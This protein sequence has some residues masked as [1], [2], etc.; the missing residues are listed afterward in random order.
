MRATAR[1][2]P[3]ADA[4]RPTGLE[5]VDYAT[6]PAWRRYGIGLYHET[7]EK[8]GRTRLSGSPPSRC[9]AA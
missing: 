9:G 8:A 3:S 6:V 4:C 5:G 1:P 7:Y 2:V